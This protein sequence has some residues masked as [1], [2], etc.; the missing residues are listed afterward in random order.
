MLKPTTKILNIEDVC[1]DAGTQTRF[2]IDESSVTNYAELMA[3][4]VVF[5]AIDVIYDGIKYYLTDGF[6]RY[7][8]HLK[9]K[10]DTIAAVV[11]NGTL[12]HAKLIAKQANAHGLRLTHAEKRKNVIEMLDDIEYCEWS[13]KV[14]ARCCNVSAAFV[15]KLRTE[16]EN[17]KPKMSAKTG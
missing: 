13:N 10:E 7:H 12:R 6:H 17:P 4:G 14:I 5:A 1:I 8:A 9:N 15:G 3:D 16:L 11:S 2:A